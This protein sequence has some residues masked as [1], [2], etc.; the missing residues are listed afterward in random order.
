ML[1][2]EL[3]TKAIRQPRTAALYQ[4]REKTLLFSSLPHAFWIP[5]SHVLAMG[6]CGTR[7]HWAILWQDR[8]CRN[9]WLYIPNVVFF[10]GRG[11]IKNLWQWLLR[12]KKTCPEKKRLAHPELQRVTFNCQYRGS[13][14]VYRNIPFNCWVPH[15]LAEVLGQSTSLDGWMEPH[16]PEQKVQKGDWGWHCANLRPLVGF[17]RKLFLS[18]PASIQRSGKKAPPPPPPKGRKHELLYYTFARQTLEA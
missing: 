6:R 15:F 13:A 14:Y 3:S 18:S 10:A 9:Y 2:A 11:F 16:S 17:G 8:G 4:Q 1:D 5:D 7:P 12:K